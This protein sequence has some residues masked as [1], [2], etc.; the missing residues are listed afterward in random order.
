MVRKQKLILGTTKS[1]AKLSVHN[2]N[3]ITKDDATPINSRSSP[4]VHSTNK[5]E[6]EAT[7]KI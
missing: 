2:S 1:T 7:L 4:N 3:Q 5:Y 6:L